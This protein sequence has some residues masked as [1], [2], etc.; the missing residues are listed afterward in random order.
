MSAAGLVVLS[1]QLVELSSL[2]LVPFPSWDGRVPAGYR[3][4][5]EGPAGAVPELP[6]AWNQASGKSRALMNVVFNPTASPPYPHRPTRVYRKK[7]HLSFIETARRNLFKFCMAD[8][9]GLKMNYLK[10]LSSMILLK[11]KLFHKKRR[12]Q[13]TNEMVGVLLPATC[14]GAIVNGAV[15]FA[16]FVSCCPSEFSDNF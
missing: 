13:E 11:D 2:G 9:S 15:L 8:S 4:L 3:C 14:M 6:H 5:A 10:V 16:G 12:P 7:L 1:L